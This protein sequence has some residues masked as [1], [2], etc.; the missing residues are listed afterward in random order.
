MNYLHTN[1]TLVRNTEY[2]WKEI[3]HDSDC[4]V[5]FTTHVT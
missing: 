1:V 4:Y 5:C 2:G 3:C